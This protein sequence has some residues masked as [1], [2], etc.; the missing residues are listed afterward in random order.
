MVDG[1]FTTSKHRQPHAAKLSYLISLEI[2][3]RHYLQL[4][5]LL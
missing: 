5:F 3:N 1:S 4:T 2:K